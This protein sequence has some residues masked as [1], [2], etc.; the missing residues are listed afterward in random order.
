MNKV[1]LSQLNVKWYLFRDA[2]IQLL[3]SPKRAEMVLGAMRLQATYGSCFASAR[4][5]AGQ[6]FSS[7]K[8]WDRLLRV[9]AEEKLVWKTR[10]QR[11]DGTLGTNLV[12]FLPLWQR[13]VKALGRILGAG[14]LKIYKRL[15]T[16]SYLL[17]KFSLEGV[18]GEVEIS[19]LK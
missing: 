14:K 7:E 1:S 16:H 4:F 2:L 12:N 17:Y 9:L 3:G 19:S 13:L 10:R 8:S 5:L 18:Y 11:P 6:A 15:I